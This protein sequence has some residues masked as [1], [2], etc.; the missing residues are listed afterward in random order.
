MLIMK[1]S[2]NSQNECYFCGNTDF[3]EHWQKVARRINKQ[4]LYVWQCPKCRLKFTG[5]I[6]NLN[7][8]SRRWYRKFKPETE[9]KP[10]GN[11]VL[12]NQTEAK[13]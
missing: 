9:S 8:A 13:Q 10:G 7:E 12:K 5:R 2:K 3:T 4:K 11:E 1:A 6:A